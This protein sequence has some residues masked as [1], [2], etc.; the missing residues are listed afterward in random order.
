[1]SFPAA[2]SRSPSPSTSPQAMLQVASLSPE[3]QPACVCNT[4]PMLRYTLLGAASFP[5]PGPGRRRRPRPPRRCCQVSSLSPETQPA[6]VCNTPPMLRYTL[7]GPFDFPPPGPG[8]RRRPHP[9]RRCSRWRRCRLKPSRPASATRRRRSGTPCWGYQE[10][11]AARSRSPSP[12]TSP[13]AMLQVASLSPET[14]PACVCNT[15]PTL[16]YTLLGAS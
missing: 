3:T 15:P 13:Q 2:R 6:C 5:P 1:M 8:R 9:P 14:Q 4:P 12:S 10:F 16:R 11:P 7:L